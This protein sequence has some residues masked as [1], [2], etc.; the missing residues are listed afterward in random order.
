L[1]RGDI[2][3]AA[4]SGDFGKPR[5]AVMVQ[6]DRL[7]GTASVLLCPLT[8]EITD[9]APIRITLDPSEENGLRKTSQIM[10]D[11]V[12]VMLR[13]RCREIIGRIDDAALQKLD[14]ALALVIGLAD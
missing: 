8:S 6:S 5:P 14:E 11:K 12:S 3:K 13:S 2:V 1:K 4:F 10:T 9:S 7:S